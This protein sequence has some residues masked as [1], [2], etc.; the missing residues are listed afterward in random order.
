MNSY[1]YW[2]GNSLLP[3]NSVGSLVVLLPKEPVYAFKETFPIG[4]IWAPTPENT[5]KLLSI[6]EF[7]FEYFA[8]F[9]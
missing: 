1:F 7:E 5:V 4:T 3:F 2:D 6:M 9:V 8:D